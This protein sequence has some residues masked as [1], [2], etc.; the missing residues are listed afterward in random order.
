MGAETG[1]VSDAKMSVASEQQVMSPTLP[2]G[3]VGVQIQ[4]SAFD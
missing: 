1:Q 4:D 3:K 2:L